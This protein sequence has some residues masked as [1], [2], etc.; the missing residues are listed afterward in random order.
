MPA[1]I[2]ARRGHHHPTG[3]EVTTLCGRQLA[4]DNGELAWLWGTC[5]DCYT[6]AC[7]AAGVD[8]TATP[9]ADEQ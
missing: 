3:T 8:A 4:A 5:P 7:R 2:R 1:P 6:S 9:E